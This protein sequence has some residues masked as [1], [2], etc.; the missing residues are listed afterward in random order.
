[1]S[2]ACLL[3]PAAEDELRQPVAPAGRAA[4][5]LEPKH[6]AGYP[7]VLIE[8]LADYR[9]D[10][11]KKAIAV[12]GEVKVPDPSPHP[13]LPSR[14]R[15]DPSARLVLAMAQHRGGHKE[16]A[17]KTLAAAVASFDWR[18]RRADSPEVWVSHVLR[19][20]AEALILPDLPAFLNGKH[21]PRDNDERLALL[22]ACEFLDRPAAAARLCAAAF[23]ADPKLAEDPRGELR[24]RAACA[25][26]RAA[27]GVGDGAGLDEDERARLRE[28]A[29]A[30]LRAE[31]DTAAGQLKGGT[32]AEARLVFV[33]LNGWRFE[34]DLAPF[35]GQ[36]A[37]DK[38]PPAEIRNGSR[39]SVT[40]SARGID[41]PIISCS[42]SPGR[43]QDVRSVTR[44][45]EPPRGGVELV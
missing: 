3:L 23:A 17:R 34:A 35:L 32:L 26:A 18:A 5:T 4:A 38:L 30:W 16:Q 22:G 39:C 14:V 12:L 6:E 45:R 29:R 42:V 27:V 20:E 19:R 24:Y 1:M 2:L 11:F 40:S 33:T 28:Q 36:N 43:S 8:G 13:M 10:R 7:Y 15:L 37:L 9:Q 44:P 41:S 21:D 25:A 31:L